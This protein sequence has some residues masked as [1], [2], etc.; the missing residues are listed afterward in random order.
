MSA[1]K[2]GPIAFI[3]DSPKRGHRAIQF[4]KGYSDTMKKALLKDL[5]EA[6]IEL[7]QQ[8]EV[9][10]FEAWKADPQFPDKE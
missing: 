4:A 3:Y 7:S 6:A 10:K 8:R 5:K 9:A 2:G 1:F